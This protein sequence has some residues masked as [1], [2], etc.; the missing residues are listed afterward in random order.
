MYWD[1]LTFQCQINHNRQLSI[2]KTQPN[3]LIILMPYHNIIAA[4]N[5]SAKLVDQ[6]N[7]NYSAQLASMPSIHPPLNTSHHRLNIDNIIYNIDI[8][9]MSGC[10]LT[11][12]TVAQM[13]MCRRMACHVR[14]QF[15]EQR[16]V[17]HLN[18]GL[19]VKFLTFGLS[20]SMNSKYPFTAPDQEMENVMTKKLH[21]L[22]AFP[23]IDP[24]YQSP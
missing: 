18:Q 9:H 14:A 5:Y 8:R 6:L 20:G 22:K 19:P 21:I 1:K 17:V 7:N 16:H 2:R 15:H 13:A 10:S 11:A 24:M 23:L 12:Q 3:I 4:N